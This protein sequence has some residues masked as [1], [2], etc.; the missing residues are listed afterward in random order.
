MQQTD[1]RNSSK[2][3]ILAIKRYQSKR[4]T[5]FVGSQSITS[6]NVCLGGHC[7]VSVEKMEFIKAGFKP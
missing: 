6:E 2:C 7:A 4:E 3:S 5:A 1:G